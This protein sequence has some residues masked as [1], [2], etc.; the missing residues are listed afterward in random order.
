MVERVAKSF[1]LHFRDGRQ[2]APIPAWA[3]FFISLGAALSASYSP[4]RRIVAALSVPTPSFAA[5]FIAL[6]RI[7]S[8]PISEPEK[9]AVDAHFDKLAALTPKTPLIYFN[10]EALYNGPFLGTE[11]LSGGDFIRMVIRGGVVC[12]IPKGRCLLVEVQP[13]SQTGN[14]AGQTVRLRNPKPF[15]GRFFSL[16]EHYRIL[17]S[18]KRSVIII[19]EKNRLRSELVQNQFAIPEGPDHV[20]GVL[21]DLIRIAKFSSGGI[22][23]RA[24]VYARSRGHAIQ[25]G[26]SGAGSSLLVLDGAVSHFRWAHEYLHS[27]SVSILSRTESEYGNAIDSANARYLTRLDDCSLL[28]LI[29]P[30]AGVELMVHLED[31][32]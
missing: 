8:E 31:R 20:E 14:P 21:Q 16:V 18:T 2:W 13:E 30:P 1:E 6:G 26:G 4:K 7:L 10:G 12:M 27:D 32:Q 22:G 28:G 17:C 3:K 23:C 25:N 11:K 24:D 29:G 5:A 15:V 9:S 19:G